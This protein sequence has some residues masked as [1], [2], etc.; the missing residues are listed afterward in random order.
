[1]DLGSLPTWAQQLG[2]LI[3]TVASAVGITWVEKRK[4]KDEPVAHPAGDA[5]VVAAT[6]VEK[7]LMERLI[8]ST[9]ALHGEIVTLNGHVADL[10]E[11]MHDE[12]IVRAAA[13]RMR[14]NRP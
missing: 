4:R 10:N 1:M 12:E 2:A 3:V 8:A 14:E 7:G 11:R 5:Q 13:A 9:S 6:F